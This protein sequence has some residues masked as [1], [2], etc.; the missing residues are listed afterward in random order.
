H[1]EQWCGAGFAGLV[2]GACVGAFQQPGA[3]THCMHGRRRR[4]CALLSV[5]LLYPG[6][7]K[8]DFKLGCVSKRR[9]LS[10]PRGRIGGR[11]GA[12]SSGRATYN[13]RG[14]GGG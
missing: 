1:E 6:G 2:C 8:N 7:A 12:R 9:E 4:C 10:P 3:S 14:G 13:R 5:V 11:V